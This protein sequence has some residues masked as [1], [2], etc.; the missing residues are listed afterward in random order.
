MEATLE[1]GQAIL[2]QPLTSTKTLYTF[3]RSEGGNSFSIEL[4]ETIPAKSDRRFGY[5]VTVMLNGIPYQ[6][7]EE[8]FDWTLYSPF[9]RANRYLVQLMKQQSW[10]EN[11]PLWVSL[12]RIYSP[13]YKAEKSDFD[14]NEHGVCINAET[15]IIVDGKR[16]LKLKL[17]QTPAKKW[18][19]VYCFDEPNSGHSSPLKCSIF[20]NDFT[21]VS[22]GEA[23]LSHTQE[24]IKKF[25]NIPTL[26]DKIKAF[27]AQ[28]QQYS[29]F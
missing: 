12:I 25:G 21:F 2:D 16:T 6:Q 5:R 7:Q 8:E 3:S 18:G 13:F 19:I 10:D 11:H 29:L 4:I 9:W 15:I 20:Y 22:R 26:I 27:Q 1:I 28:Y 24:L 14:F 23:L 17:A